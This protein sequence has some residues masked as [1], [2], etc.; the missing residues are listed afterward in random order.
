MSVASNGHNFQYLG[1]SFNWF[2]NIFTLCCGELNP[3]ETANPAGDAFYSAVNKYFQ[4]GKLAGV[5]SLAS[6]V[7]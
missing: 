1:Y 5:R 7:D 4:S 6:K 3:V 2:H